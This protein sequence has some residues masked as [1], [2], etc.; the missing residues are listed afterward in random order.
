[1][2]QSAPL[3]TLEAFCRHL[4]KSN[5]FLANRVDRM[6][7][8]DLVDV[9]DIHQ[10][11]FERLLDLGRQAQ[12][13][14][15]GLGVAVWGEA[16]VGK[17][18]LLARLARWAS[19]Q[20]CFIY[21]H[22]LQASPERLPRYLVKCVLNVLTSGQA[23][24]LWRTDLH[25]LVNAA[26]REALGSEHVKGAPWSEIEPAYHRWVDNLAA[27]GTAPGVPPDRTVQEVLLHF[28]R[29]AHPRAAGSDES[30]A[31]LAVRWLA[32]DYLDVVEAR[33][34]GLRPEEGPDGAVALFDNQHIKQVL[35]GLTRI[36]RS[37]RRLFVLCF[38][39]V[40]NLD[41]EQVRALSRFLHDVLD[42]A[43]NL[44]V[45]TTGVRH[46]LNSYLD[47]GTITETSWDR[48]GQFTLSPGRIRA[49]QGRSLLAARLEKFLEP[50][51]RV[52]EIAARRQQDALFPLG[53][54]WYQQR[55]GHL[56]DFR[57]RD[58]LTW[59]GERWQRLQEGLRDL[60]P[61]DWLLRWPGVP[62]S[63]PPG[64]EISLE[65]AIDQKVDQKIVEQ[66]AL[67]RREPHG[68]LASDDNLIGLVYGLLR[69]CLGQPELYALSEVR[70]TPRAG[71]LPTYDL[72][73]CQRRTV[74]GTEQ[75]GVRIVTAD[76]SRSAAA[77]LRRLVEDPD[78]PERVLL[79]TDERQPLPLGP[80]GQEYLD[81][82][83]QRG[84][85]RFQH[86][87]L[88]FEEYS[89]LDALQAVAGLARAGDLE[90]D[91]PAGQRR[92]VSDAEVI[93]SHHRRQRY[94]TRP[95]LRELLVVPGQIKSYADAPGCWT[96]S[97]AGF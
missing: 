72:L 94:L 26:V 22:N 62:E 55:V 32:G 90:V 67:R 37:A 57:P 89:A 38:D 52:P 91:Y 5:P 61:R 21:L 88:P 33:Q 92:P 11:E 27:G 30:V 69:Q 76:N 41:E 2:I 10:A 8:A 24:P 74:E 14:N 23:S 80:R 97:S 45:V 40:D 34:I 60:P 42:S 75:I 86:L 29:A 54:S 13:E 28:F 19:D 43:G 48:I 79:V 20:A 70:L 25:R 82:L 65:E 36:A 17:S 3:T 84:P 46:T 15:R 16:G 44:L 77:S 56:P 4:Q 71:S 35:V 68:L 59:A 50:V 93:A 83:K 51:G 39:Q 53:T 1:M 47:R 64:P 31:R 81:E 66:A 78:R 18:H 63:V 7:T 95:L 49:A 73:V 58:L 96:P 12:T 85:E 87:E 6:L 9:T